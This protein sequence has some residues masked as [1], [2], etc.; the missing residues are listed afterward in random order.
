MW[1]RNQR[2]NFKTFS[3]LVRTQRLTERYRRVYLVS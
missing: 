2:C 3:G 1:H